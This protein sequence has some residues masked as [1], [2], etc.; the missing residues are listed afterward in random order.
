MASHVDVVLVALANIRQ[1]ARTLNLA[2]ALRD[3]GYT[4]AVIAAGDLN[5]EEITMFTWADPGTSAFGRWRSLNAFVRTI[6]VTARLVLGMDLFALQAAWGL[7][8]RSRAPL[9]YDMREFYFSL[10]PLRGRGLKQKLIARHE[11]WLLRHVQT[12]MVSGYLDASIVQERFRLRY[13]PPV[14]LNTPPLRSVVSGT[15]LRDTFNI[16]ESGICILYQG[17][18]HHGR[19]IEPM[20]KAMALQENIHLCIVGSGPAISDLQACSHEHGLSHRIHWHPAVDY[21]ELHAI[22]CSADVG[23]CLVEPVSES[24][25]YALPNKLFEYMMAR[26][27]VLATDLPALREQLRRI[28]AGMLVQETLTPVAILDVLNRLL[29]PATYSAMQEACRRVAS[30]SYERQSADVIQQMPL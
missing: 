20:M 19:G 18:V 14:L 10:G 24:Y 9:W 13:R 12:V 17:V 23:L 22:T 6:P 11:R 4:V 5:G 2:R 16:P 8:R 3:R 7:A 15:Y 28:P 1:D 25:R 26:V 30:V 27:P 21:D 29:V